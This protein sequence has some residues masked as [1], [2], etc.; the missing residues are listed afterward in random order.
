MTIYVGDCEDCR[1]S[2][3]TEVKK[4]FRILSDIIEI[5]NNQHLNNPDLQNTILFKV[6]GNNFHPLKVS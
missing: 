6:W 4:N 1:G 2:W 5:E 3:L